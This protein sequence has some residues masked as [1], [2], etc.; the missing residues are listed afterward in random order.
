MNFLDAIKHIHKDEK[1]RLKE[2]Q[3]SQWLE[4]SKSDYNH[5]MLVREEND[6]YA[7]EPFNPTIEQLSSEDWI[8]EK[9][10]YELNKDFKPNKELWSQIKYEVVEETDHSYTLVRDYL[11]SY[12]KYIIDVSWDKKKGIDSFKIQKQFISED[13][14]YVDEF[15]TPS[16]KWRLETD[17]LNLIGKYEVIGYQIVEH[18]CSYDNDELET[19]YDDNKTSYPKSKEE[20]WEQINN[21][22]KLYG[23]SHNYSRNER[24]VLDEEN[25]RLDLKEGDERYDSYYIIPEKNENGK[26]LTLFLDLTHIRDP[27]VQHEVD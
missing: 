25:K 1:V 7:Y 22:V 9:D 5:L 12:G 10:E 3:Y 20:A 6:K 2:W 13:E 17:F 15:F 14:S 26:F 16:E 27:R 8:A 24:W 19:Y 21:E 4:E 18:S 23:D 11:N